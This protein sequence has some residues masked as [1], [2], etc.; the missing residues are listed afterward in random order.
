MTTTTQA[1]T[2]QAPVAP[3]P[4]SAADKL[5]LTITAA[6]AALRDGSLTSLELLGKVR[7]RARALDGNL[8]VFMIRTD[9][10]A[11]AAATQADTELAQGQDRG[12]LHGIP[13]G[14][15]DIISTR[16]AP[17][18]AQSKIL[19][20]EFSD[21]GDAVVVARLRAAGAVITGKATTSEFACGMPD[22]SKGFP[23]PR[24]PF[25]TDYWTGGSSAGTGGG[26]AAGLFLGGLGTDT[27]GSIR[28]PAA[29]CGISGMKQTF[30]R[31]PKSGCVPLGFSYD[32]IGP[33]ARS[34]RDCA[35][36]LS[37][38]AGYD[39]SDACSVDRPVDD[40]VGALT[41]SV[42]GLRL[43]VDVSTLDSPRCNPDIAAMTLNAIEVFRDAG[44]HVTEITLPLADEVV[45]A[46]MTG[47][48]GEAF[49][50]HRA[51]LQKRWADYGRSARRVLG[52]GAMLTASDYVQMQR[53][54]RVALRSVQEIFTSHD[55]VINPT[56]L[57]PA[58]TGNETSYEGLAGTVLTP[59]WNAM[60]YPAMSIPMGRTALGLPA[61]LQLAGRPFDEAT[62]FRA[63]DVFQSLTDHHLVES[64]Y[65]LETIT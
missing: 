43:A 25:D 1:R 63:A 8:G 21:Q 4:L 45:T 39:E 3:A 37:V 22:D 54:R 15:K 32:H 55:L 35:A 27:G 56:C 30:G 7:D 6:A 10:Q 5:P 19:R 48:F 53:V 61:G 51:D 38:L 42:V 46:T 57:I 29:W 44:A 31:V 49:A 59:Y 33:M 26:V 20:A 65:V 12:P 16:D 62:V 18:T 41:G 11:L 28:I 50:Y 64:P 17:S 24:N 13:L 34:A 2:T 36:M 47:L 40:Y 60:G 52:T 58:T 9:E 14:I 23:R